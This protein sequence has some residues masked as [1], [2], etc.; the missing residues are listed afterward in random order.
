[1]AGWAWRCPAARPPPLRWDTKNGH[2]AS[3]SIAQAPGIAAFHFV[4]ESGQ[5]KLDL[6]ASFQLAND[7]MGQEIT[8]SGLT[9]EQFIVRVLGMLSSKEIDERIFS[10]PLE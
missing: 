10:E 4:N 2:K 6:V 9:E 5:W 7:A 3:A 1:V 8:K